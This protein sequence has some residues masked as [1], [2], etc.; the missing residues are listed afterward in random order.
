[1]ILADLHA[2]CFGVPSVN[3]VN[4]S[5]YL[6]CQSRFGLGL[7]SIVGVKIVFLNYSAICQYIKKSREHASLLGEHLNDKLVFV[8]GHAFLPFVRLRYHSRMSES[9]KVPRKQFEAVIG[10][11]LKQSPKKAVPAPKLDP[12]KSAERSGRS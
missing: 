7:K 2:K 10:N 9:P 6:F 4:I 11:L 12:G 5:T 1:M 3:Q 8:L